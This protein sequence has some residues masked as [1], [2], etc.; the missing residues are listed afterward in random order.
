MKVY[1]S[2]KNGAAADNKVL[3]HCAPGEFVIAQDKEAGYSVS[4][5]KIFIINVFSGVR[6]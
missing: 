1:G 2:T 3:T 5:G 6:S 4:Y